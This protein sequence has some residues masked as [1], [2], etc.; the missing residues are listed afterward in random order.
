MLVQIRIL[1]KAANRDYSWQIA[2]TA[3]PSTTLPSGRDDNFVAQREL[4]REIV[5]FKTELSSRPEGSVVEGLRLMRF[6][7]GSKIGIWTALLQKV[8]G[9]RGLGR[10]RY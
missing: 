3:G 4:P 2:L 8:T 1:T 5:D 7:G 6:A 9:R 10:K